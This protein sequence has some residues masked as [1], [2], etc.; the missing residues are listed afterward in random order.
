MAKNGSS[1]VQ[2]G[3]PQR[4]VMQRVSLHQMR[5]VKQSDND[6]Y[7]RCLDTGY[8]EDVFVRLPVSKSGNCE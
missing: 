3:E 6:E 4:A 8:G 2:T 1:P 7:S 5:Q